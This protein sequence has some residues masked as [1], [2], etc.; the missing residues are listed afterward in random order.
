MITLLVLACCI[1]SPEW[2]NPRAVAGQFMETYRPIA[3]MDV[4]DGGAYVTYGP[5]NA[6]IAG[7]GDNDI[8][9]APDHLPDDYDV[10]SVAPTV[11]RN[12]D[13]YYQCQG[14]KCEQLDWNVTK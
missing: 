2:Q 5:L 1:D 10:N 6:V 12:G 4:T 3:A 13:V 14:L 8:L 11:V 9:Q 7:G